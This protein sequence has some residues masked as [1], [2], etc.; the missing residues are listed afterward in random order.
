M[1]DPYQELLAGRANQELPMKVFVGTGNGIRTFILL[2]NGE[3]ERT[4]EESHLVPSSPYKMSTIYILPNATA[5]YETRPYDIEVPEEYFGTAML[6]KDRQHGIESVNAFAAHPNGTNPLTAQILP[7]KLF[8][9]E[10]DD[11]TMWY[12]LTFSDGTASKIIKVS[13]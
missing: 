5:E 8:K 7:R 1:A 10:Y 4:I 12:I 2:A 11:F 13:P 3:I 6:A 9:M